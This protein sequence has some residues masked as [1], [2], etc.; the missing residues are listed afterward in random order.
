MNGEK[1]ILSAPYGE[2]PGA[3]DAQPVI[4]LMTL[5]GLLLSICLGLV[6]TFEYPS[7]VFLAFAFMLGIAP[8][9]A[10]LVVF[11][12]ERRG[13]EAVGALSVAR[14]AVKIPLLWLLLALLA[15][16]ALVIEH[17]PIVTPTRQMSILSMAIGAAV[18]LA[19]RLTKVSRTRGFLDGALIVALALAVFAMSPFNPPNRVPI[20]LVQYALEAP[21]FWGWLL[22]GAAWTA[23]GLW[24]RRREGWAFGAWRRSL[25]ALAI[26]IGAIVVLLMYDDSHFTD[27]SHYM[28][29]IGPAMHAMRGGIPM[30]DVYSV[31]GLGPWL[32]HRAMFELFSPTFGTAA[33]T[34]RVVNVLYFATILAMLCC[35]TR[36]RLSAM[37]FFIPAILVALTSHGS[38]GLDGMWNMNALPMTLGGRNLLPALMALVMV[39]SRGRDWGRWVAL[40]IIMLAALSSVEILVFVLAS[41]G[42]TLLLDSVRTRSVR[43]LVIWLMLAVVAIALAHLVFVAIVY[44]STGAIVDYRPYFSLFF[45]F[46]PAEESIWSVPFVP[47]YAMWAPIGFAYFTIMAMAGLRA[48][49]GESPNSII[50]RL[51]PVVAFGLGP[52]SYFMGRPQEGTLNVTCLSF[53]V[54]AISL[55]ECLFIKAS[56]FGGGAVVLS[57]VMAVAFAFIVADGFEHFMRPTDPSRGNSSILRRCLSADGCSFGEVGR[58]IWL[59]LHTYPLDQRTGV[60]FGVHDD[61][62]RQR[63]EEVVD[64]MRRLTSRAPKVGVLA[65]LFPLIFADSDPAIGITAFMYTG[66]WYAWS[67]SSPIND[68]VSPLA[69]EKILQQVAA[70]SSGLVIIV[71]NQTDGWAPLNKAILERLHKTCDFK[72]LETGR[73]H[74]AFMMEG[75]RK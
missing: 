74:S 37:W 62:H 46:R 38:G 39:V 63:I 57:R 73:Y 53:A 6:L 54:V 60:G 65:D 59:A 1:A 36:R 3:R 48:L 50:D 30:V 26:C 40:S 44:L 17:G 31:Y 41:W 45:Q 66:Q 56:R 67:V 28:P 22:V 7:V 14:L 12:S 13:L 68:G 18:L 69:S 58:N 33:V 49:R 35:V 32:V 15:L 61:G 75:C 64:M 34:V 11:G 21:G 43:L 9:I 2:T 23:V 29:L 24:L 16:V 25:E 8:L 52:L 47:Y 70:T 19:L 10:A 55:A 27:F 71:P 20:G 72:A 42:Y 51:L 5:G 4:D